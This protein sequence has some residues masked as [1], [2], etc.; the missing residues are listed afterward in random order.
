MDYLIIMF[1]YYFLSVYHS[2]E[3][4]VCTPAVEKDAPEEIVRVRERAD[5]VAVGVMAAAPFPPFATV[6]AEA[7]EEE[8]FWDR[9]ARGELGKFEEELMDMARGR[10]RARLES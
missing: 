9:P 7:E 1:Y 8:E 5:G 4:S 3:S 6:A 10:L 2:R